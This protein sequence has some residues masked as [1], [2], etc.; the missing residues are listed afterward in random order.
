MMTLS[1]THLINRILEGDT[2]GFAIL[3]DRYKDLA[4]TIACRITGNREDAEEIVQDAFVKAFRSLSSFR[5]QSRF[6]TW[7]YRIVYNAAISKKRLKGITMQRLD[8]HPHTDFLPDADPDPEAERREMLEKAM[9]KLPEEDRVVLT[10]YYI[11]EL[12][13]EEIHQ[14]TGLSKANVKIRLF[15]ARKKLQE[16]IS[17]PALAIYG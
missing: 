1:D 15:R 6:S 7:L 17:Q 9:L 12:P 2:A 8:D 14:V 16:W 3:V 10:L 11:E 13:V 4:F 5:R